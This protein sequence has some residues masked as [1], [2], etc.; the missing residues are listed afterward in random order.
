MVDSPV[1]EPSDTQGPEPEDTGEPW[2]EENRDADGDGYLDDDCNDLDPSAHPG[3]EET[4]DGQD[5]DCDGAVDEHTVSDGDQ[6]WGTLEHETEHTGT[7]FLFPDEDVD[8]VTFYVE[9]GAWNWFNVEVWL[10]QVPQ[11]ADLGL[12]LYKDGVW[13]MDVDERG[14]G[15]FEKL[16]YGGESGADDSGWY[17]AEVW[18]ADGASCSSPYQLQVVV[19]SW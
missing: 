10:Y 15:D 9:D 4:C 11:G 18:S 8:T 2:W 19:G 5:D 12:S 3:A 7:A 17:T 16:N 13:V 14:P 6:D 1:S